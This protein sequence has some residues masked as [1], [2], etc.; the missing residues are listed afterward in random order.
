MDAKLV[1]R[2]QAWALT[3]PGGEL[4]P[5]IDTDM[6]FH[7]AH[8]HITDIA[9]M[10]AHSL[11]NLDGWKDFPQ[12]ARP[13]DIVVAGANFG[14]GSSRQQAVDCFRAL[15]ISAIIAASFG[16]IY[17]RNAINGAFPVAALPALKNWD[18]ANPPLI[19]GDEIEADFENGVI[20]NLTR[21]TQ[22]NGMTKWSAVQKEIYLA[23]GLLNLKAAG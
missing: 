7:N 1:F 16:A 22:I 23:G 19:S 2:G 5:D 21:A 4:I 15:G 14:C 18:A 12:R 8:L 3:G 11:G 9:K 20:R 13:G 10:G 17:L 6:I